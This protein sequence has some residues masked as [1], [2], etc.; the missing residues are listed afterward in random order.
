MGIMYTNTTYIR[1]CVA[2]LERD[3]GERARQDLCDRL[4]HGTVD[5]YMEKEFV[6]IEDHHIA[7]EYLC[8]RIGTTRAALE[9]LQRVRLSYMGPAATLVLGAPT[10]RDA[11][12]NAVKLTRLQAGVTV[13][14][15]VTPKGMTILDRPRDDLVAEFPRAVHIY[16]ATITAIMAEIMK[17]GAHDYLDECVISV[18]WPRPRNAGIAEA[19]LGGVRIEWDSKGPDVSGFWPAKVLDAPILTGSPSTYAISEAYLD[20]YLN[21]PDAPKMVDTPFTSVVQTEIEMMPVEDISLDRVAERMHMSASGLR[22]K[23]ASEGVSFTDAKNAVLL[24]RAKRMAREGA[25]KTEAATALDKAQSN[26]GVWFEDQ[27]GVSYAEYQR[28]HSDH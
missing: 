4:R 21:N 23:I 17:A 12:I 7:L 26:F 14:A 6:H 25:T 16:I 9:F 10:V 20:S 2:L 8:E 5:S 19:M 28:M 15:E 18:P 24:E 27:A 1:L 13:R 22:K 3:G 11:V